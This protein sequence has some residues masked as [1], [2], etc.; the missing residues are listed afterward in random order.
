M[1]CDD[2]LHY[3]SLLLEGAKALKQRSVAR[4][5]VTLLFLWNQSRSSRGLPGKEEQES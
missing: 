5:G 2:K 3:T 4:T 1:Q